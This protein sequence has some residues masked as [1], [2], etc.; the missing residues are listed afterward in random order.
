MSDFRFGFSLLVLSAPP[1][2]VA[3]VL[4][5]E[6]YHPRPGDRPLPP[7]LRVAA[8]RVSYRD[9]DDQT[10]RITLVSYDSAWFQASRGEQ[11]ERRARSELIRHWNGRRG[12]A[13]ESLNATTDDERRAAAAAVEPFAMTIDGQQAA[14][15]AIADPPLLAIWTQHGQTGVI[16]SGNLDELAAPDLQHVPTDDLVTARRALSTAHD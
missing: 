6:L 13:R 15:W 4:T 8:V 9:P 7:E 14:A 1:P 12:A 10:L 11:I 5:N 16:V 3:T 2:G